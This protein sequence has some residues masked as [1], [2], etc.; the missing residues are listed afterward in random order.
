MGSWRVSDCRTTTC[1][2]TK[3]DKQFLYSG[4]TLVMMFPI[5]P[6]YL[7]LWYSYI[8]MHFIKLVWD[9]FISSKLCSQLAGINTHQSRIT[10][11]SPKT[12]Q[13][14][15]HIISFPVYPP[16]S[17]T[18]FCLEECKPA[19]PQQLCLHGIQLYSAHAYNFL[20]LI[21]LHAPRPRTSCS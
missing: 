15:V 8:Y 19:H 2:R 13:Q 5:R 1:T 7:V 9:Q 20:L 17:P 6:Q 14:S 10:Q 3:P 4:R 21:F 11:G 12:N 16:A 18:P